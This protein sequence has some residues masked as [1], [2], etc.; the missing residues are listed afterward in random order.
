MNRNWN[1]NSKTLSDENFI[2]QLH[3]TAKMFNKYINA[4]MLFIANDGRDNPLVYYEVAIKA[5]RFMHLAGCTTKIV[6]P[7]LLY[8]KDFFR[9]CLDKTIKREDFGF[10]HN[11]NIASGKLL[12]LQQSLQYNHAKLFKIGD[13]TTSTK[14]NEFHFA[15]GNSNAIIAYTY[16]DNSGQAIPTSAMCEPLEEYVVK[17]FKIICILIKNIDDKLYCDIHSSI[18]DKLEDILNRTDITCPELLSQ[19]DMNELFKK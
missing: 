3:S 7:R 1:S 6:E 4:K 2:K 17:S 8:A 16:V 14:N 10:V 19:I 13:K 11:K 12:A 15:V 18:T 9:K 5:E